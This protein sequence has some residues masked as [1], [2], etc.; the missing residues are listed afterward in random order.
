MGQIKNIKLHIVT[1]IKQRYSMATRQV[2]AR[3]VNWAAL[4]ARVPKDGKSAAGFEELRIKFE[5]SKGTLNTMPEKPTQS[6][7]IITHLS[8]R[9]KSCLKNSNLPMQSC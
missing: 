9:T 5:T 7:G 2:A 8:L 4:A 1:D 6:T 3:A